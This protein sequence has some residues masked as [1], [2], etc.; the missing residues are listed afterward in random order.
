MKSITLSC[1]LVL[2]LVFGAQA[3][4]KVRERD[5]K[6]QWHLVFDFDEEFVEEELSEEDVPWLG[7]IIAKGVSGIVL[8][9]LDEVDI[10]FEFDRDNRLKILVDVFGEEEVEYAH[11]YIDSQGA[12]ILDDDEDDNDIWLFNQGK[13][14]AYEKHNGQLERQPVYL[15]RT[16]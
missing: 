9:I 2:F 1:L 12:L 3:Q 14:Y 5:L 7:R 4:K 16:N 10:S 11:W 6:G 13:L 8:D 15:V